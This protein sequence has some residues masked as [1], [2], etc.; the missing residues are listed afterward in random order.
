MKYIAVFALFITL[1]ACIVTGEDAENKSSEK[2]LLFKVAPV[3]VCLSKKIIMPK[4]AEYNDVEREIR[5]IEP[6]DNKEN[7]LMVVK[8]QYENIA[9]RSISVDKA[10]L[11]IKNKEKWYQM[12]ERH[13]F[14]LYVDDYWCS[15]NN[16]LDI[17]EKREQYYFFEIPNQ[18]KNGEC[19]FYP[20]IGIYDLRDS[21]DYEKSYKLPLGKLS[22]MKKFD[23]YPPQ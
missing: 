8:V 22:E 6:N 16:R 5:P 14:S 13:V 12:P 3:S 7:L 10:Y 2:K 17:L 18:L 1:N 15:F 19:Y 23:V 9:D 4:S 21:S 20:D 11:G